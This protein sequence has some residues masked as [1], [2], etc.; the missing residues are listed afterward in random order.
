MDI[1]SDVSGLLNTIGVLVVLTNIITQVLKKAT[2]DKLPTNILAILVS[3]ALTLTSF[4]AYCNIKDIALEWYYIIAAIVAGFLVAY[5]A[6]LGFDKLKQ[7]LNQIVTFKIVDVEETEEAE[8]AEA[9]EE[10]AEATVSEAS[11]D[12]VVSLSSMTLAELKDTAVS[13]GIELSEAKTK[14][15]VMEVIVTY[16]LTGEVGSTGDDGAEAAQEETTAAEDTAADTV[17]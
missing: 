16:L 14:K 4:F 7:A 3:Q 15:E 1:F 2:Y 13:L 10:A 5:A 17:E 11:I 8:T 12:T 6:M 9:T